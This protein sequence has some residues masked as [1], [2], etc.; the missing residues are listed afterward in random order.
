MSFTRYVCAFIL[1]IYFEY[2]IYLNVDSS[3]GGSGSGSSIQDT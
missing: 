1:G 3:G 2:L